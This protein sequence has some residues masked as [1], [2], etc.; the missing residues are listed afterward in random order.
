MCSNKELAKKLNDKGLILII[1]LWILAIVSLLCVGLA[2]R[3]IVNLKLSRL[4]RGRMQCLYIAKA[5]IKQALNI[6][7]NDPTPDFDMLNELWSKGYVEG[8][9]EEG[10]ILKDVEVGKGKFTIKYAYN[11]S[12]GSMVY[13]YG[14]SDEDRK[15]N[16]NKA[17]RE[18]L[19]SLFSVI[20]FEDAETLAENIIYWRGDAP[21]EYKDSYYESSDIPYAARKAPL[22]TIEELY[23]V[24]DFREDHVLIDNCRD[25]LTVYTEYNKINI[26]TA[27]REVLKAVFMGLGAESIGSGFSDRL[28]NNVLNFRDGDDNQQATDDDMPINADE[29]KIAINTGLINPAEIEW[30][31]GQVFSFT[32]ESNLF[33]IDV[34]AE[35]N[36]SKSKNKITAIVKKDSVPFKIKYWS[37]E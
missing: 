12:V 32:A 10:L 17:S 33:R 14:M 29:I 35:L 3:V 30:V 28:A 13:F 1:S 18:S 27:S 36:S 25:Y 2:H 21:E 7:E 15:M 37:E 34:A 22:K 19:V 9:G 23:L 16:I 11:N 6:L 5:G 20:G 31:N 8:V 26:N 24:K 4:A